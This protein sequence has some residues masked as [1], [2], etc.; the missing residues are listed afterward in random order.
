[1]R[2]AI[3][4]ALF[5]LTVLPIAQQ[6]SPVI[7]GQRLEELAWPEAERLLTPETVV[8]I[9]LAAGSQQHGHHLKLR[10]DVTMADYLTRRVVDAA[11]VVVAPTLTY[12]HYPAFVEYP[13][14][15]SLSLN[16]ARDLTTDVVRTL[17]AYGPRRFYVLNTGISTLQ[18][19]KLAAD[20]L[21]A[22]GIL[23]RFTDLDARVA[24]VAKG[25]MQQQGGSHADE[26]ETSMMLF[27]DPS[28]VDM[29]KALRNLT[30]GPPPAR[31]TRQPGGAGAYS[32][33]G[34]WGDPT[35]A[36]AAKGQT[37]VEGLVA[38]LLDDIA[39][40]R[41]APLPSRTQA[42]AAPGAGRS[43]AQRGNAPRSLYPDD[44]GCTQGDDREIRAIAS[45]YTDLWNQKDARNFA[46]LWALRGNI[47]HPDGTIER[48]VVI[49]PNRLRLF[50]TREHRFSK[51][52]LT[53][54]LV[55]CLSSDIAVVDG[56]W[57][58]IDVVDAAGQP[59][60]I[61]EGRVTIVVK[62]TNSN[63][64]IEAYRYTVK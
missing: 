55:R 44:E 25:L 39:Q 57:E 21:A 16:T 7:K 32:S 38:G 46:G 33:S 13:G 31:L 51:H 52:P 28:S 1:M 34:V 2:V 58:L 54:T 6:P 26:V 53:L 20:A 36:T 17:A 56:R 35:L 10:N 29:T 14:S 18:P 22:D 4:A 24:P 43:T 19:L 30:A 3:A 37:L 12:H 47:I 27:I 50:S 42:P 9:P 5:A 45:A 23:L 59:V 60:P 49:E 62:R 41:T 8:V 15:P 48:K 64:L 63:W 61:R 40:L 11:S